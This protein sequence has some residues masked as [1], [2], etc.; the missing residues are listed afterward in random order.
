MSFYWVEF[1]DG[2][3][4]TIEADG[5][6]DAHNTARAVNPDSP[7][8]VFSLPYPAEPTL[9]KIDT[10]TFCWKPNECKGRTSCPGKPSCVS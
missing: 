5:I 9:M 10:P 1:E 8:E 2:Q 4:G 7:R 6:E 3:K